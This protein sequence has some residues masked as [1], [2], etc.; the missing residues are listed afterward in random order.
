MRNTVAYVLGWRGIILALALICLGCTE[1]GTATV[2]CG[3]VDMFSGNIGTINMPH[4][5]LGSIVVINLKS[6][7]AFYLT[8]VAPTD[9]QVTTSPT[10]DKEKQ[11]FSAELS[12]E[13][14]AN[15]P[16]TVQAELRTILAQSTVLEGTG[17][18]RKSMNDV[19]TIVDS[20]AHAKQAIKKV[21]ESANSPDLLYA[22]V[23]STVTY[24]DSL[25]VKVDEDASSAV[26]ANVLKV[27]NFEITVKY[28]CEGYAQLSG[29]QFGAFFKPTYL[30]YDAGNDRLTLDTSAAIKLEEIDLQHAK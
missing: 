13:V 11:G 30:K 29:D 4:F 28:N 7:R 18:T 6:K 8:T 16:Q 24:A 25:N 23:I 22:M 26:S 3:K 21:F 2:H 20:N 1:T 19:L 14:S 5:A 10:V 12:V 15:V 27:G 17:L 9:E